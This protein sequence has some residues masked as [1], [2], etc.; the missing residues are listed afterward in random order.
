LVIA[1]ALVD[2]TW[3][4]MVGM[5]LFGGGTTAGLQGRYTAV[6]LA[7]PD[8]RA[9]QISIVIWA[10][11]VGAVAGPMLAAPADR[12]AGSYGLP[13]LTGPFFFS[14]LGFAAAA[15][16]VLVLLR[17]DPLLTARTLPELNPAEPTASEPRAPA[18][19]E[20]ATGVESETGPRRQAT[21][22]RPM[23]RALQEVLRRPD[24]L[25]GL[26]AVAGGHAVMLGVMVMTPIH[27]DVMLTGG[28]SHAAH[29]GHGSGVQAEVLKMVGYVLSLHVVGM[30][31][32]S[33]LVGHVADRRGRR[34]VLFAGGLLLVVSCALAGSAGERGWQLSGAL[35]LLGLGWSCT[36]IAGSTLLSESMPLAVRPAAQ[37]L[38]DLVMGLAGAAAGALSGVV[39]GLAGYP[40]LTAVAALIVVPLLAVAWPRATRSKQVTV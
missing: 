12:L 37:G 16:L 26:L 31:A 35:F 18:P 8:Q 22:S 33:P 24:A 30:F 11:T 36:L 21:A 2:S 4:V 10:G 15:V 25:L 6:D 29:G 34:P 7:P 17:P 3:L 1:A 5:L 13:P 32:F 28:G 9:R 23:A 38:S 19:L 27:I 40:M 39:V 20:A 14:M